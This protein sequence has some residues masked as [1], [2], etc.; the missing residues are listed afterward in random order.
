MFTEISP[1]ICLAFEFQVETFNLEILRMESKESNRLLIF[2]QGRPLLEENI[3]GTP[4][5]GEPRLSGIPVS[6]V[7]E[8]RSLVKTSKSLTVRPVDLVNLVITFNLLKLVA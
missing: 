3:V 2:L 5:L 1:N 8:T 4:N 7:G 6:L